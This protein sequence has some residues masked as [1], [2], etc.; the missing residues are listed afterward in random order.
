MRL[1]SGLRFGKTVPVTRGLVVRFEGGATDY[2]ITRIDEHESRVA[3]RPAHFAGRESWQSPSDLLAMEDRKPERP[4]TGNRIQTAE[5]DDVL[6]VRGPRAGLRGRLVHRGATVL[7]APWSGPSVVV[8]PK[9]VIVAERRYGNADAPSEALRQAYLQE[10]RRAGERADR[11]LQSF[12]GADQADS[13]AYRLVRLV[14]IDLYDGKDLE[15]SLARHEATWRKYAAEQARKVAAAPKL[16][17]G[18]SAGH[19]AIAHRWVSPDYFQ[20]QASHVRT[21]ARIL[22]ERTT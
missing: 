11:M 5:E 17:R 12:S 7:V 14:W 10:A 18:P 21:M 8:D 15:E 6:V 20:G 19:S 13:E 4:H 1:K 22:K 9:H 3:V 16:R 2:Q